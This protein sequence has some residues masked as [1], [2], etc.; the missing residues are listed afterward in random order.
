MTKAHL[1]TAAC[2]LLAF[3]AVAA[4][5][6]P[7]WPEGVNVD[8]KGFAPYVEPYLL[9]TATPLG[10]VIVCP[11]GG[12]GGRAKHEGE[13]VARK[14]NALGFH[15]FVLQYR[16]APNRYPAP[17][18]DVFR[19]IRLIRSRAEAMKIAPDK[20]AVLG[21]SAGGH[22]TASAGTLFEEVN[23][24]AGDAVDS[25]SQRPDA[26][27]P[28]YP[29]INILEKW[30]HRGSGHNLLGDQLDAE[31]IPLCLETRVTGNTP[32]AFLWH[33]AEDGGVP[34]RNSIE[35]AE[36]CWRNK[37]KAELHVFPTGNHGIGLAEKY[38]DASRWPELAAQFLKTTCRFPARD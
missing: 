25:F 19:A 15:A 16:V 28:C 24:N 38:P 31:G 26:I 17:Q 18:Q 6:I 30:G 35:F 9:E 14:F 7:L 1:V 2:A 4:E 29:V 11:G 10:V 32:P 22:L 3:S 27:I 8:A 12:Y 5:K 33:T 13:P 20:I 23:A 34:V 21:F 36:A 37:V